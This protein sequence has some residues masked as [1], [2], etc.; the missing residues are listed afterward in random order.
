MTR[1]TKILILALTILAVGSTVTAS[2]LFAYYH[3][4]SQ[5]ERIVAE[6]GARIIL[7]SNEKPSIDVV[8]DLGAITNQ[9]LRAEMMPGDMFLI[10]PK[11]GKV[12]I[13]RPSTRQVVDVASIVSAGTSRSFESGIPQEYVDRANRSGL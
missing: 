1:G 2:W 10:Y 12:F 11:A 5:E 6:V 4:P 7:P 8:N 9:Q 13:W 3:K